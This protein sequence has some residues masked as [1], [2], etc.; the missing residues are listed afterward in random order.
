MA[1]SIVKPNAG[2]V[3]VFWKLLTATPYNRTAISKSIK[4]G[5]VAMA[6]VCGSV[7]DNRAVSAIKFLMNKQRNCLILDVHLE[8]E[9]SSGVVDA[10]V[11]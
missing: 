3:T 5:E 9:C 1:M 11:L 2:K 7:E 6:M 4:V 8:D 10:A